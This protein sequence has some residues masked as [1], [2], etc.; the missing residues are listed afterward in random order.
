MIQVPI[1]E[2]RFD[3][4][5]LF[6][7][8]LLQVIVT[9]A[10]MDLY[11][12]T[13]TFGTQQGEAPTKP[14]GLA[15]GQDLATENLA[16]TGDQ[17]GRLPCLAKYPTAVKRNAVGNFYVLQAPNW[18]NSDVILDTYMHQ[19]VNEAEKLP[20]KDR[21]TLTPELTKQMRDKVKLAIKP[22]TTVLNYLAKQ[23]FQSLYLGKT[24]GSVTIPYDIRPCVGRTYRVKDMA[25]ND[26]FIGFLR[27]IH[28]SVTLTADQGSQAFTHLAFSHIRMAGAQLDQLLS[29]ITDEAPFK[30]EKYDESFLEQSILP[31]EIIT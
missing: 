22:R 14:I 24:A 10:N 6:E 23:Y 2:V 15:G 4:A 9:S 26:I 31:E 11:V 12:Y 17:W 1:Q 16:G 13:G 25:G 8:P 30:M 27:E 7:Q 19:L 20:D 5:H 29:T 21:F 18:V 28:H 3:C